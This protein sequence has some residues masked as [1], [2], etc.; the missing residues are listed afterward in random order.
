MNWRLISA[1][2]QRQR[3]AS[4]GCA[5]FLYKL[6]CSLKEKLILGWFRENQAI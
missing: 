3:G 4:N 1:V 2:D 6:K 5:Q